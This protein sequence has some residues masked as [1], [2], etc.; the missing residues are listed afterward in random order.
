MRAKV[1]KDLLCVPG[2]VHI[3]PIS[4][5]ALAGAPVEAIRAAGF[6]YLLRNPQESGAD[7]LHVEILRTCT[8]IHAEA[9]AILYGQNS[10]QID[11]LL[12]AIPFFESLSSLAR[13]LM[14]HVEICHNRPR[15][16]Y[17]H[18]ALLEREPLSGELVFMQKRWESTLF[19][20]AA[21][22]GK[23]KKLDIS[24]DI[25]KDDYQ[26]ERAKMAG[27]IVRC[28]DKRYA[29]EAEFGDLRLENKSYRDHIG[30]IIEVKLKLTKEKHDNDDDNQDR[31]HNDVCWK[32]CSCCVPNRY[33]D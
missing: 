24:S 27:A 12:S 9:M 11:D 10:F 22:F 15:G 5:T 16:E 20:L 31:D 30:V 23:L 6:E 19:Y 29:W 32:Y 18:T 8:L 25:F 26:S 7:G 3:R 28:H 13:L 14:E 21:N 2:G 17:L 1:Y 33:R 4:A